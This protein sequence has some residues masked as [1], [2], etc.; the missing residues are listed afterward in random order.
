MLKI[1]QAPEKVLSHQAEKVEKVDRSILKLIG[2][3]KQTLEAARDPEGVGLA[4]PQVG[5]SL[6]LF[7][8]KESPD[9]TVRIF[10]NPTLE[11]LSPLQAEQAEGTTRR[12]KNND[13]VKLEGC[14]SIKD[15]WGIVK[16]S[17]KVKITYMDEHEKTHTEEVTGFFAIILQHEFDHI[18]GTLF[19]KRVIEQGEKLYRS[20]KDKKGEMVFEEIEI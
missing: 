5:R 6:Q 17:P 4:A 15:I 13:G 3:M 19:T 10:I 1:V 18:N 9:A 7:I 8:V 12:K 20:S 16:R 2:E 11:L 14:L